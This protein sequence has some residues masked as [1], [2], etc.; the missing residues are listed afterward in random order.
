MVSLRDS[1]KSSRGLRQGD[2]HSPYLSVMVMEVLSGL[3]RR[4]S[5]SPSY[6][7]HWKCQDIRL[8]HLYFDDDLMVFST[9]IVGSVRSIKHTLS[10][11]GALSRL[12]MNVLKSEIFFGT[13]EEDIVVIT[14]EYGFSRGTL[15]TDTWV[16][17][18]SPRGSSR[19][20]VSLW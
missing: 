11:F 10:V 18:L 1:F 14:E 3:F 19:L 6:G 20:I 5:Q 16:F 15:P 2:P 8:S 13:M 17:P 9:G 12:H 7:Y 4:M